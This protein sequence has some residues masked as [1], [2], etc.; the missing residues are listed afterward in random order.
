MLNLYSGFCVSKKNNVV[1]RTRILESESLVNRSAY[2]LFK[3]RTSTEELLTTFTG[4][5]GSANDY[6]QVQYAN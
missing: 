6:Y 3:L 2:I 4:E 5:C 1:S